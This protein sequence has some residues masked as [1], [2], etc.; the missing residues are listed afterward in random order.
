MKNNKKNGIG[1]PTWIKLVIIII[2][3]IIL[4]FCVFIMYDVIDNKIIITSLTASDM[5]MYIGTIYSGIITFYITYLAFK[6]NKKAND[7]KTYIENNKKLA[8]IK[9]D[10]S[11][12]ITK[13]NH[14]YNI[15]IT[16]KKKKLINNLFLFDLDLCYKGKD[17]YINKK[18]YIDDIFKKS[19]YY[20]D[21]NNFRF[22]NNLM[23]MNIELFYEDEDCNLIT[24]N[25]YL[26]KGGEYYSSGSH[27]IDKNQYYN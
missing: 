15:K 20:I 27:Y 17:K 12:N 23:P 4:Y 14:K 3:P 5:L 21:K 1:N 19:K 6:E 13:N 2:A 18:F 22:N 9:P 10:I 8:K 7:L 26:Q 16:N 24:E 11:I 25:F